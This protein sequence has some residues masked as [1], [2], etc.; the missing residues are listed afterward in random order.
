MDSMDTFLL[1]WPRIGNFIQ[2]VN[3]L[4]LISSGK[5]SKVCPYYVQHFYVNEILCAKVTKYKTSL[6][7]LVNQRKY[8]DTNFTLNNVCGHLIFEKNVNWF[9]NKGLH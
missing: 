5:V 2:F 9:V 3:L 4:N 7:F 8:I 6:V 1:K